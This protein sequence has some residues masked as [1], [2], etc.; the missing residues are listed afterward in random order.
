MAILFAIVLVVVTTACVYPFMAKMWWTPA[1]ASVQGVNFDKHFMLSL[2]LC[3]IIMVPA[4]LALAYCIVAFKDKGGAK[5]DYSHGNNVMEL[6]WTTLALV[7]FIGMNVLG[8]SMWAEQRFTP[9]S[10]DSLQ[11]EVTGEQFAWN[12]RYPG[13]DGKFGKTDYTLIDNSAGNPVG[14]DPNDPAGKDDVLATT[15]VVPVNRPLEVILHSKD[16]THNFFVAEMR[17]KQD[18]VPGMDLRIHF[19]PNR[20]GKYEIA[21]SELCGL[22]HYKMRSFMEVVSQAKYDQWLKD[23]AR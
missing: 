16:V 1:L 8:Q 17:I 9:A 12:M 6:M 2:I 10:A 23:H 21:C 7:F 11:V 5:A 3:G 4:Q 14:L 19:T 15:L 13:P 18:A 20:E 22:G